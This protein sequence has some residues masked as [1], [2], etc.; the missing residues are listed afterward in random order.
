MIG[1]IDALMVRAGLNRD[2]VK[3]RA[4]SGAILGLTVVAIDRVLGFGS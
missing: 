3:R 2:T 1:R 4:L